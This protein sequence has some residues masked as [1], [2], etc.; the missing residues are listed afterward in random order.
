LVHWLITAVFIA[1]I[2]EP[3]YGSSTLTASTNGSTTEYVVN[4]LDSVCDSANSSTADEICT[5]IKYGG[6]QYAT[7][8]QIYALFMFLWCMNFF[9]AFGQMVLAGAFASY[10]WAFDK[11]KDVPTCP[12]LSSIGRTLRYHIG[13]IAFGS[14][15]I[16][17][18]QLA[19]IAMEYIDQKCKDQ[20]T[21][22]TAFIIKC[23]K[24][25]L[26]CFEKCMKFLNKNA[27][28]LCAVY[29]KN[30][31]V[32][33]KNAFFLLI[34]NALRVV[35]VDKV[36][37]FL[38]LL[39]QLVITAIS[40]LLAFAAFT[41]ELSTL[42]GQDDF[43]EWMAEN[44]KLTYFFVPIIVICIV[45]FF[46]SIVFFSVYSMAVDTVFMCFL[47]DLERHDGSAEKPY[48]M[49]SGLM[50]VVG[51]KNMKEGGK[52]SKCC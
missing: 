51:V 34:R 41:N 29:G 2:V 22:I 8:M 9:I 31:C 21:P 38:I 3:V 17:V 24:C 35:V 28:I 26:W 44:T 7:Y 23:L 52:K 30:F 5:F 6:Q 1:S 10:Y 40:G 36:T 43:T 48:F 37:D 11:S 13:T 32:S 49:P 15:I 4:A 50:N 39:G 47:E 27:Y 45:V 16:A 46:I 18:I 25:C 20:Q 42:V 12:L 14:F 19:R 33:A